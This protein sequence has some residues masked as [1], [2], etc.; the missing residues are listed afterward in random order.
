[1]ITKL[2]EREEITFM[3]VARHYM[4]LNTHLLD[5][6]VMDSLIEMQP[7]SKEAR[8]S[9]LRDVI[10]PQELRNKEIYLQKLA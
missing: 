2:I 3:G 5:V 7:P 6:G 8:Y 10:A 4:S 1:L 9:L